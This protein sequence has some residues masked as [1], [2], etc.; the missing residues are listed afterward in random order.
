MDGR[1]ALVTGANRGIG[2][3]VCRQLAARGL[4]VVLTARD[5]REGEAAAR[6]LRQNE[7]DVVFCPL[8]VTD[9]AA[10]AAAQAF[11]EERYGRLDV[12]VN[13]A[14]IYPDEGRSIFDVPLETVDETMRVNFYGPLLLCRAF[15]PGM[16][17][18]NYGRIVNVSSD[19][20]ALNT[21]GAGTPS[22]SISKAALNALTRIVAA[23]T[24][25]NVK[26]NAVC[27][28]W[29]RTGMGGAAAPRSVAEGAD[30]IVW[31][32]TLPDAGPSGGFF[33]DRRPR[34]W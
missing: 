8:D 2:L 11:V 23:E 20:G 22:Y 24:G 30:T 5:P 31:L 9:P 21:M 19:A 4:R 33:R 6:Q 27:P 12:L 16:R 10:V 26:V 14:A 32:A 18:R 17:R 7:S 1:I 29:V 3:E 34:P 13:N 28:G 15:A 25:G